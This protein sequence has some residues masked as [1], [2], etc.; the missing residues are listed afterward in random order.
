MSKRIF[1]SIRKRASGRY[2]ASYWHEGKLHAAPEMFRAKA[3][4]SAYLSGVESD[5][6]R[7]GWIDPRAGTVTLK[8]YA[9]GWIER[10]PDLSVR[11]V[12]LYR[13]LLDRHVI[14]TLG[15]TTLAGLSPSNV[16]GW[17]ATLAKQYQV[18]AA[19]AYRLLAT[20]LKTAVTDGLILSSP[21]KVKGAGVERSP[22]RPLATIAE[23]QALADAMPARMRL[24]VLLATWCQLRRGELLG[25]RRCDVDVLHATVSVEQARTILD[26]GRS[27]VKAPKTKA[28][29]R[30][31]AVPGNVVEVL[32]D[33]L[34]RFVAVEAEALIFTGE[35]GGPLSPITI[36]KAWK[37]AR[38]TIGRPEL[39][40]H[41]LRHVGL[42]LAAATGA[43]TAELMHRAGH[44]SPAAA[45]RYQHATRDRDKIIADALEALSKP[46]SVI[47]IRSAE[48]ASE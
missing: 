45:L 27:V 10:R 41:D 8:E 47:P 44:A 26:S 7:G 1:G 29:R 13:C 22:E 18:T 32:S 21:C 30:T 4:A 6:R 33:H 35:R 43:T 46:A 23:V 15:S 16:R 25:L 20:I 38:A 5:I 31:I 48:T 28:G 17:H 36:N 39:H 9:S 2:Q 11:T 42:T 14:P 34:A 3:T 24:L 19:K 12:E 37:A 40:L